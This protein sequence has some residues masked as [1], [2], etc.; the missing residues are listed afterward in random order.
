ML[1]HIERECEL[2]FSILVLAYA[3]IF[4][5]FCTIL[6]LR[7][8]LLR[9]SIS[10]RGHALFSKTD[11]RRPERKTL[12]TPHHFTRTT[13]YT[14]VANTAERKDSL[15]NFQTFSPFPF[16]TFVCLPLLLSWKKY[17]GSANKMQHELYVYNITSTQYS[18][19]QPLFWRIRNLHRREGGKVENRKGNGG[20]RSIQL[21]WQV[22]AD[23]LTLV[24]VPSFS[25]YSFHFNG[26]TKKVEK[27]FFFV[28]S[29]IQKGNKN[30]DIIHMYLMFKPETA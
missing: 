27:N 26:H 20:S 30:Y 18:F 24:N 19:V 17:I 1:S 23:W 13:D 3:K 21:V 9:I 10:A 6:L 2:G 28:P 11:V 15:A 5:C 25:Q 7:T 4:T 29:E 16:N 8:I 14:S 22:L 12:L